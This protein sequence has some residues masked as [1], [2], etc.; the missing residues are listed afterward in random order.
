MSLK[1]HFITVTGSVQSI[2]NLI[3]QDRVTDFVDIKDCAKD[4]K[5]K[6]N[7]RENA[8]GL[9]L[10]IPLANKKQLLV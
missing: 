3:E 5:T 10:S 6:I 4:Y 9:L 1:Y 8:Y 2:F 7:D